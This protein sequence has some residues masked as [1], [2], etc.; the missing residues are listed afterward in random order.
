MK[1]FLLL[2][3]VVALGAAV[4]TRSWRRLIVSD[5]SNTTASG[6]SGT[7]SFSSPTRELGLVHAAN[8]AGDPPVAQKTTM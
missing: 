4:A 8:S 1:K 2:L 6:S 7:R 3:I 5:V